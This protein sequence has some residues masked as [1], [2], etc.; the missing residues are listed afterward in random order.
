MDLRD[1]IGCS[2]DWTCNELWEKGD[3]ESKISEAGY[4]LN[5][6]KID[7]QRVAPSLESKKADAYRQK[8]IHHGQGAPKKMVDGINDEIGIFEIAQ[9]AQIPNDAQD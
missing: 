8:D 6:F 3:K 2:N 9:T 4:G 5:L 1:E 7:I